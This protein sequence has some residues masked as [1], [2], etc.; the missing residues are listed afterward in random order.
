V[1]KLREDDDECLKG[2]DME[3]K[4]EKPPLVPERI[5]RI[6]GQSFAF[7][8]HRFLRDGF[9]CALSADEQRLYLFLVLAAD[10]SGMSFYH[11]D[12]I[13][14]ILEMVGDDYIDARNGLIKKD[15]I[16]FDGSR[17]QVLSLP[18][19]PVYPIASSARMRVN[20]DDEDC[21]TIRAE[22]LS[23]LEQARRDFR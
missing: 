9:L 8:Q 5:R 10:R 3:T 15:L 20:V 23:S 1:P 18:A 19:K 11:Y 2:K 21:A 12:R 16:A 4:C 17:F 14:S 7:L 13:C 6:D 22:I